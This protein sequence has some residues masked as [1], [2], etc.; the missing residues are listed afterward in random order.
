MSTLTQRRKD[1]ETRRDAGTRLADQHYRLVAL[2]HGVGLALLALHLYVRTLPPTPT[3]IPAPDSAEAA[4]WGFWPVTYLP[5]WAVWAGVLAVLGTMAAW[6]LAARRGVPARAAVLLRRLP[7]PLTLLT[8]ISLALVAAFFAFPIV[9]TRWGDAFMLA[10]GIAWPD[11]A[12]RLTHSWQ[13]PLALRSSTGKRS[14][15]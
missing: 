5:D 13:A 2:L 7:R 14:P 11:P 1:A 10:K 8:L 9:H 6:W 4:W 12:L 3:A 15:S